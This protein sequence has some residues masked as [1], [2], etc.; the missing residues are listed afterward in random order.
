MRQLLVANWSP[1][2]TVNITFIKAIISGIK[3]QDS[4]LELLKDKLGLFLRLL[5]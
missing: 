2:I 4:T 3:V 1:H 5:K